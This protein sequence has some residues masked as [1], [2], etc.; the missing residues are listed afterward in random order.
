MNRDSDDT[1]FDHFVPLEQVNAG[2]QGVLV[3]LGTGDATVQRLM[4]MGLI[5]GAIVKVVRVAPLGDPIM[6]E[7]AG[8]QVC[9]RRREAIGIC[10][11]T[12][13]TDPLDPSSAL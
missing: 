5:P 2:D 12:S 4:S 9:V 6:L 11:N 10:I 13:V 1:A 8:Y 3:H 7:V